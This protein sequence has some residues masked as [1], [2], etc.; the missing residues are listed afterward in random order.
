MLRSSSE[1]RRSRRGV[2][3]HATACAGAAALL[4]ALAAAQAGASD[5]LDSELGGFG[6]EDETFQ[7]DS[8]S[9]A[10]AA[11]PIESRWWDLDGSL[12]L[13]ASY[14]YRDHDAWENPVEETD[15]QGLSRLRTRLNLQLDVDLPGAWELRVSPYAWYDSAYR[16]HGMGEYSDKVTD[17]Y[18]WEFGFSDTYLQGELFENVDVKIG[19]QVVAWGRSESLRVVDLLNPLDSREPARADLEDLRWSVAMLRVDWQIDPNWRLTGLYIPELRFDDLPE[20]GSDFNPLPRIPIREIKPESFEDPEFALSLAGAFSGWDLSF[21]LADV[22]NDVPRPHLVAPSAKNPFGVL[23]KYDRLRMAGATGNYTV[24]AWLF[25]AEAAALHGLRFTGDPDGLF[26]PAAPRMSS[27]RWRGDVL[28]GVEYYGWSETTVALEAVERHLFGWDDWMQR[29]PSWT[30]R[31]AAQIALRWTREWFHAR[32][33][34]T[35]VGIFFGGWS[36]G[37]TPFDDGAIVRVQGDYTIRDGLVATLGLLLYQ[38]GDTGPLDA[39]G[40]NDRIFFDLK[41]SF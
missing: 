18:V 34:T 8:E 15:W 24:G 27:E 17:E 40:H 29:E 26:L 2:P 14:N 23:L 3:G 41:Y 32:L 33:T 25:K 4:L 30:R 20:S 7:L 5:A 36:G 22:W 37:A 6:D 13:S 38:K 35:A 21:H 12:A 31:D 39:W 16:I 28:L 1:T 11:A 19:R 10:A 9:E